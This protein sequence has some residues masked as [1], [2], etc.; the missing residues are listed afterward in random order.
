MS[1]KG[2]DRFR[3]FWRFVRLSL[4]S[5]RGSKIRG[6]FIGEDWWLN[7]LVLF[8]TD[9]TRFRRTAGFQTCLKLTPGRE[10]AIRHELRS[11]L[12]SLRYVRAA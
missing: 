3:V 2:K 10:P 8:F 7:L 6:L 5:V 12:G 1:R 11:R 9:G 4:R